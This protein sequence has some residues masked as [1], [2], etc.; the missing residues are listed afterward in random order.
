MGKIV[1]YKK[2]IATFSA[3]AWLAFIFSAFRGFH[4]W[5]AG[6][7]FFLWLALGLVNYDKN[8]SFWFLKNRFAGFL[9]FF[10]ILVFLSFV[11]DFIMGQKLAV[12]WWY[13][14]YNSLDDWLRLYFIIYPFGGLAVLELVYFLS[15]IFGERLNF[16]QRPYTYA[17][18]LTDKLDV[19]LL[20][21]I[22]IITLLAIGGLTREYANLVIW[23]FFAWMFFGT[24]KLKYHIVHWGHYVAILVT[25]LF[26]SVFLHEI[27]NVGVFE[28]Q[29]KNAPSL[30][31]EILGI[32]LWVVLGWYLLVLGM[33]RIWMYLVLKPRQK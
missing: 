20:L 15:G 27:P 31:Q 29:Y 22:L 19:G 23:G 21:S 17:H 30:N 10:L 18:R 28:W 7:V 4:F 24:L 8:S 3:I 1:K 12:L 14:H 26:M 2:V 16:V 6:F 11:A 32:P 25:A 9:R 13:P 5:Y 33:V